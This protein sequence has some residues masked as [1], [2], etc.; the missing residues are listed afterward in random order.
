VVELLPR[1][2][3]EGGRAV[4]YDVAYPRAAFDGQSMMWT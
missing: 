2:Q 1:F 3:I 4:D